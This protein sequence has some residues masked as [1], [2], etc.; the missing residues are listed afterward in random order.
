MAV[1]ENGSFNC[2]SVV[3]MIYLSPLFFFASVYFCMFHIVM[4]HY[5]MSPTNVTIPFLLSSD[6]VLSDE[7][8]TP[9]PPT[10]FSNDFGIAHSGAV[11]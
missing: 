2:Q 1:S 4:M 10:P 7:S 11:T 5:Y 3:E 9:R 6:E 8:R